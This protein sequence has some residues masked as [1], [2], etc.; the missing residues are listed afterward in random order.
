MAIEEVYDQMVAGLPACSAVVPKLK[1]FVGHRHCNIVLKENV[2][3]MV[4]SLGTP[5]VASVVLSSYSSRR[6]RDV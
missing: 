1:Y 5:T 6:G 2:G 4:G 3:F